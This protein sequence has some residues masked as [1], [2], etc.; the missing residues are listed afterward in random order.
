MSNVD[1]RKFLIGSVASSAI[2]LGDMVLGD[3]GL[4][5][6]ALAEE[7]SGA[8]PK[9]RLGLVTY[10][11]GKDWDLPLLLANCT[12]TQFEGIEL[13][14]THKHGVE[15]TLNQQQRGEVRRRFD[16]S[17]VSLVGLG[18]ACEY[19][20]PDIAVVKRN[21]EETKAFILCCHDLGGGG[22][23]V[24][25]NGLPNGVPAEKTIEQIGRSLNE[26][27][28]F[29]ADHGVEIRV[30]V[31]GRE[32]SDIPTFKKIMDAAAHP[33]CKMCWN[34]N[35]ADLNGKGLAN[36][37]ALL[38]EHLGETIHIHDLRNEANYPWKELF[39]LLGEISYK[40]WT[41]IE[42]GRVP[43]DIVSAMRENRVIW[44]QLAS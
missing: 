20:S 19:H 21:I 9:M 11:W 40:G 12:A 15:P 35:R 27:A 2:V 10:Q 30:E 18:S 24:R 26:V 17:P 6:L 34:C 31:H 36:N 25:P 14:S 38:S 43:K 23:K 7:S 3:R 28:R 4:S 39:G 22:V 42:E 33:N 32:T 44:E 29:G 1:R 37:F 13:R 8:V 5:P 16:D 41:L